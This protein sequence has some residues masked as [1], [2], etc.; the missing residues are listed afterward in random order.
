MT[1]TTTIMIRH[2]F[3]HV[4]DLRCSQ[5]DTT[6]NRYQTLSSRCS[7]SSG[8]HISCSSQAEF[9]NHRDGVTCNGTQLYMEQF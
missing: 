3:K 7:T 8:T 1:A 5:H 2:E 4:L 9:K 6:S